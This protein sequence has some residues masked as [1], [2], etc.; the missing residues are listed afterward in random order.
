MID[1]PRTR[2]EAE[3]VR[4]DQWAGNPK[5]TAYDPKRC[6]AEVRP[7]PYWHSYQCSRA[8]IAGIYCNQHDKMKKEREG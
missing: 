7:A 2:E 6:A 3:R 8:P 5:G 1:A 4:Y